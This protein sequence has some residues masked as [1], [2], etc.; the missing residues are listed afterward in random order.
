MQSWIVSFRYVSSF[1][2][3]SFSSFS[4]QCFF[5]LSFSI[6][7]FFFLT[8]LPFLI[9]YLLFHFFF[10]N[11]SFQFFVGSD[12]FFL[13]SFLPYLFF[14]LVLLA[15][16][17]VKFNELFQEP[18]CDSWR[19]Y[20]IFTYWVRNTSSM[21]HESQALFGGVVFFLTAI[22]FRTTTFFSMKLCEFYVLGG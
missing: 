4:V 1:F 9:L 15:L 17:L 22:S 13:S 12:F 16:P 19:K 2:V 10:F 18:Q 11:F 8:Y 21:P 7:I 6:S 5:S 20:S 3:T 14:V